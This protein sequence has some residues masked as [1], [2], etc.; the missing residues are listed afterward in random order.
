MKK[1]TDRKLERDPHEENPPEIR[2]VGDHADANQ[3]KKGAS[4]AGKT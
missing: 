4:D 2:R 1:Q 3:V